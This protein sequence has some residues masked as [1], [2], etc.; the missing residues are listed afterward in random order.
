[1]LQRGFVKAAYQSAL[2]GIFDTF[3]H[4]PRRGDKVRTLNIPNRVL[5]W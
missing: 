5:V 4:N 1:M 2:V 3:L